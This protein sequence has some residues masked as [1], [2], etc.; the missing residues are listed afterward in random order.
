MFAF[1]FV[2]P[3]M[4]RCTLDL[5]SVTFCAVPLAAPCPPQN[6]RYTSSGQSVVV[7]WDASVFATMYTVYN[8]SG[9]GPS[10]LCSTAGLSCQLSDLDPATAEVTAS[11]EQGESAP[12]RDITGNRKHN[13]QGSHQ[14][15]MID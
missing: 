5:V 15:G 6:V 13:L 2:I 4:A 10:S 7:S 11:S 1:L 3:A 14:C 8:V 9:T 12:T